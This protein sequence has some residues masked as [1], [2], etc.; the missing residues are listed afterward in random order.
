M[1]VVPEGHTKPKLVLQQDT[2]EQQIGYSKS[3]NWFEST[4]DMVGNVGELWCIQPLIFQSLLIW[5][6]GYYDW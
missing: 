5:S 1:T 2:T 3:I 6:Y 4:K